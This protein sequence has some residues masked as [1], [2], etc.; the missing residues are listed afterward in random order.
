MATATDTRHSNKYQRKGQGYV[1]F[2][3]KA[4]ALNL[5]ENIKLRLP[6]IALSSIPLTMRF[7]EVVQSPTASI[8]CIGFVCPIV[9][10]NHVR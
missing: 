6:Q 3:W 10:V 9:L 5:V 7:D 8:F 4:L 1:F 2:D